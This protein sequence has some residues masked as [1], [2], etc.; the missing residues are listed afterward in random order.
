MTASV[1]NPD[2]KTPRKMIHLVVAKHS[3]AGKGTV[4]ED[5]GSA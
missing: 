2:G 4:Q 5:Q 3:I 1:T